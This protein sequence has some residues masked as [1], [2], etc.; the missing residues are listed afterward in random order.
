MVKKYKLNNDPNFNIYYK[1]ENME[2]TDFNSYYDINPRRP[3]S[4]VGFTSDVFLNPQS[5]IFE[6][7]DIDDLEQYNKLENR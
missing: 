2:N 3:D 1:S 4:F 6:P 5:I 7:D